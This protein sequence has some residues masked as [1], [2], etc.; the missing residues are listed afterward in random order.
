[1]GYVCSIDQTTHESE[2]ELHIH[3]R[4][5]KVKL[6]DYY[7]K[8]ES[9]F[10]IATGALIPYTE[11]MTRDKYLAQEFV[12]KK[13]IRHLIKVKPEVAKVWA[14]NYLKKRKEEKKLIYAPSQIELR[15]LLC[16]S[17]RYYDSIGGYYNLTRT[18]G[19]QERYMDA[20]LTFKP[21]PAN[22]VIVQDSREQNPL[23]LSRKTVIAKVSEGDYAL[24]KPYDKGIYIE[25][26]SLADL[27]GTVSFKGNARFRRELSRAA[28]A[29]HYIVMLVET[30]GDI[31]A[32]DYLPQIQHAK[33]S[34][35]YVAKQLRDLLTD[36][37]LSFQAL[38][39]NGRDVAAQTVIKIFELGEQVRNV[40]LHDA[41][42]KGDL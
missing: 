28:K 16:P 17:K 41:W 15:T 33:A 20:T 22:A 31:E 13:S 32:N 34:P 40:D 4:S 11:S 10:D 8:H 18:L 29:G 7:E 26:K 19:F 38:F 27:V 24:A 36:Y 1:M 5:L 35:S 37:P 42:E 3:L 30:E 2:R 6:K 21:L 39:V 14:I 23:Q 25:R 12:S 9:R